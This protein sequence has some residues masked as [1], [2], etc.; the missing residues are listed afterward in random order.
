MQRLQGL[1]AS[2]LRHFRQVLTKGMATDVSAVAEASNS[3]AKA[4]TGRQEHVRFVTPQNK[5]R[6]FARRV[7][8]RQLQVAVSKEWMVG[9][10]A[11][12]FGSSGTARR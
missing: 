9:G 12:E 4:L 3:P 8:A 5:R 2:L 11:R 1:Q 10:I 7:L 6:N